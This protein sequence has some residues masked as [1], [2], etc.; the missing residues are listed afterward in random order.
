MFW[1]FRELI[2]ISMGALG[3]DVSMESADMVIMTDELTKL[4]QMISLS[5]YTK[6]IVMLNILLVLFI[7]LAIMLIN[8]FPSLQSLLLQL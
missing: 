6:K 2:G 5:K 3:S 8:F 7:K 4:P 1:Q